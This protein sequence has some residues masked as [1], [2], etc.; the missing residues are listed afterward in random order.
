MTISA[1]TVTLIANRIFISLIRFRAR[2]E[3]CLIFDSLK[4]WWRP[5]LLL[6]KMFFE[7]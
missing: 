3:H 5:I 2:S 6:I 4:F 7:N 1:S